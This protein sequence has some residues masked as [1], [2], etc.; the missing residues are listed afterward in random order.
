MT[1]ENNLTRTCVALGTMFL[2]GAA[3]MSCSGDDDTKGVGSEDASVS[4]VVT[5][6]D[7]IGETGRT[8]AEDDATNSP[9]TGEGGESTVDTGDRTDKGKK[10]AA[11]G[12]AKKPEKGAAGGPAEKPEKGVAG[13]PAEKP[14]KG[15]ADVDTCGCVDQNGNCHPGDGPKDCRT[16]GGLCLTCAAGQSCTNGQ[17]GNP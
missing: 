2:L 17:C 4:G 3:V 13:G 1:L 6:P 11:G 7:D 15:P 16:G 10:G 9:A 8:A 5:D 12:P 14:A